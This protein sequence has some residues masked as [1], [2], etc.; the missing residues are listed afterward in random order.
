MNGTLQRKATRPDEQ[1]LCKKWVTVW[2]GDTDNVR[3]INAAMARWSTSD[4]GVIHTAVE[5]ESDGWQAPT[6]R[7]VGNGGKWE[8]VGGVHPAFDRREHW[9]G[10]S[11]DGDV[12][13]LPDETTD[14]TA[15]TDAAAATKAVSLH[16][17]NK[18]LLSK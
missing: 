3:V 9:R 2:N 8:F 10:D 13:D 4:R 16:F 5:D 11:D 12:T 6:A 18:S 1:L 14:V 15:E 7:L 17:P